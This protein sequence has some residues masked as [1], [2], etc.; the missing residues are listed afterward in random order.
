VGGVRDGGELEPLQGA[1]QRLAT[2][3]E[4]APADGRPVMPGVSI[5]GGGLVERVRVT[6]SDTGEKKGAMTSVA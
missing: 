4:A 2:V 3:A 5:D 6:G 1:R